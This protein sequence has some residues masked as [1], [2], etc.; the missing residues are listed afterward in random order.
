[1]T[2]SPEGA[3]VARHHH[4]QMLKL[5][6]KGFYRELINYGVN[7]G[8]IITVA[9]HLLDNLMQKD[10]A[11]K[12]DT[13]YYNQLF[14]IPDIRDEW[15]ARQRLTLQDVCLRPVE[16]GVIPQVAAWL[17]DPGVRE[18]FIPAFPD[19]AGE[20]PRYFQDAGRQYFG[21]Y[22]QEQPAGIIGAENLDP[23]TAKL[24]MRKL[25]GSAQRGKGVGKRATFLF[26]YHTFEVRR[27]NKVYLHSTDINIRNLNLNSKFGFELE[28]VFFEEALAQGQ[29]RD[30][31]RMGLRAQRWRQLFA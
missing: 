14:R 12:S 9:G 8:E 7:K 23:G 20:L 30:V 6:A 10:L 1:M 21:V 11:T 2:D 25:V 15:A 27:F 29:L 4:E 24:E 3:P 18:S 5:V 13:A 26:L 22:Y 16:P 28:G 17:G 31:V 19:T